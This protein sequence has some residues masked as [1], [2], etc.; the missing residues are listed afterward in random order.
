MPHLQ[1]LPLCPIQ[2]LKFVRKRIQPVFNEKASE[3]SVS[4]IRYINTGSS[5]V[6]WGLR[7][8]VKF[9]F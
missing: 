3:I 9:V 8:Q 7:S 6:A 5:R 2:S 4:E 1:I